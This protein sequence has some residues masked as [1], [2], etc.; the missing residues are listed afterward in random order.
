MML[1]AVE[2]PAF[3][4]GQ[5]CCVELFCGLRGENEVWVWREGVILGCRDDGLIG[6]HVRGERM[7]RFVP[8][9]LVYASHV[10]GALFGGSVEVGHA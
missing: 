4:P 2:P 9:K 5:Q 1:G 3:V 7:I 10:D 8:P 6:I